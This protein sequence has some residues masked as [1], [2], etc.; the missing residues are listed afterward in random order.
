[1]DKGQLITE[2]R[3]LAPKS[4]LRIRHSYFTPRTSCFL[5]A[6]I[7][8]DA[9]YAVEPQPSGIA[10]YSRRLIESLATLESKHRFLLC[11][12]LS[13]FRR[14]RQFL[15]PQAPD[16]SCAPRFSNRFFQEH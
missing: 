11:Y 4:S 9:T 10:V 5:M 2:A 3:I 13:R 7:G 16:G 12:R 6:T 15:R 8:L 14:R 1:M